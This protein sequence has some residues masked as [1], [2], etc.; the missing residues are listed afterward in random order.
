MG[1][2]KTDKWLTKEQV[3]RRIKKT[4]ARV[5]QLINEGHFETRRR[6]NTGFYVEIKEDSI[7]KYLEWRKLPRTRRLKLYQEAQ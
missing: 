4:P 5:G 3:A 7:K 2:A 6:G 1:M